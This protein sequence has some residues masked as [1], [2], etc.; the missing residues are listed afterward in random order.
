MTDAFRSSRHARPITVSDWRDGED[1]A[2]WHMTTHLGFLDAVVTPGGVDAG[3]DVIATS[4][5][6]QVK[7]YTDKLVGAPEIQQARGAAFSVQSVLFYALSGYTP[8]AVSA[9]TNA[10]VALF[11]YSV[12]GDVE[13]ANE[14]AIDLIASSPHHQGATGEA[15]QTP[16]SVAAAREA[17]KDTWA[18]RDP[19]SESGA[20]LNDNE[21]DVRDAHSRRRIAAYQR[22]N[23]EF[24][25]VFRN[26]RGLG[27]RRL[28]DL[29]VFI[30]ARVSQQ[31]LHLA[32]AIGTSAM[33]NPF[34]P[35]YDLARRANSSQEL[36]RDQILGSFGDART[37]EDWMVDLIRWHAMHEAIIAEW[38]LDQ[39][40]SRNLLAGE[41]PRV[42]ESDLLALQATSSLVDHAIPRLWNERDLFLTPGE[43]FDRRVDIRH[44]P[45]VTSNLFGLDREGLLD[46]MADAISDEHVTLL[47]W[48]NTPLS[49]GTFA[50]AQP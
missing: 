32:G 38:M 25:L 23:E 34:M 14:L 3:I 26:L 43:V 35:E 40:T 15:P 21:L 20:E 18:G 16:D 19:G 7:H 36:L 47:R 46:L 24:T 27:G 22:Q 8:V 17:G 9:A 12:Y 30:V 2:Q 49:R 1:L 6:A 4:A 28:H 13:P 29:R 41:R 45:F 37:W 10:H 31:L 44:K 39:W 5:A 48:A 11:T 42:R 50:L 33:Y